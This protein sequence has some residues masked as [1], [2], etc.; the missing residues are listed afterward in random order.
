MYYPLTEMRVLRLQVIS[1]PKV[2]CTEEA[3][4]GPIP[5]LRPKDRSLTPSH[6]AQPVPG[7]GPRGKADSLPAPG[8]QGPHGH[9]P[10]SGLG[11]G[12]SP[13]RRPWAPTCPAHHPH[14]RVRSPG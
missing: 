4:R 3:L 6:P 2:T 11:V 10:T 7:T 1:L 12:R 13:K 5:R 9:R 8:S 14:R